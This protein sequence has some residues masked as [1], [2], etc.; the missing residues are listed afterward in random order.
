MKVFTLLAVLCSLVAAVELEP[1]QARARRLPMKSTTRPEK[2]NSAARMAP[3]RVP[4]S[5]P[6]GYRVGTDAPSVRLDKANLKRLPAEYSR[7]LMT[8][9]NSPDFYECRSAVCSIDIPPR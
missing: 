1:R 2:S 7:R 3:P 4:A 8:R 5:A 6:S 9:Q